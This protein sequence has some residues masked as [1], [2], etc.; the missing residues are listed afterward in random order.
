[1]GK[2]I[3]IISIKGGVGKTTAVSNLG[4][5]LSRN[6]SK[7][8]LLVDA[9]F[10]AAN[11]GLHLGIVNPEI[12]LQDVLTG[13]KSVKDAIQKH[14]IGF[15]ILPAGIVPKK[16]DPLKLKDKLAEIKNDYDFI[17]IDSSPAL[18]EEIL[19]AM[20]ASDELLVITSPDYPTLSCTMHAVKIAKRKGVPITG[21]VLNK[22]RG[23]SFELSMED[24][25]NACNVPIV[26]VLPD[27]V[28]VMEAL[29][30]TTPHS[31][32]SPYAE[33]AIEYKKLAAAISGEKYADPRLFSKMK[34]FF[35]STIPRQEI[36]RE[37]LREE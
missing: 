32:H 8:V 22:T 23:K 25:E 5:V 31:V 21:L 6:F 7:K 28:K 2:V 26:A 33:G 1:M 37:I 24:I 9:N 35:S 15:D 13:K 34:S 16:V 20:T 12:T 18:N 14:D 11:L 10:S 4:A 19:G 27:D 29:A 36:N 3:G 17:L 30:E